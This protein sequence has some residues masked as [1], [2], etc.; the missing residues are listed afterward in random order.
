[1]KSNFELHFVVFFYQEA[2]YC[3]DNDNFIAINL[4]GIP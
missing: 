2:Y 4:H 1:M 3:L